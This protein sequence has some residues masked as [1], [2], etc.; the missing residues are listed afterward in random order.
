VTVLA[1][2]PLAALASL[3]LALRSVARNGR[4]LLTC[5]FNVD[6]VVRI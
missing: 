6:F 2:K 3:R 5:K 1:V 4:V